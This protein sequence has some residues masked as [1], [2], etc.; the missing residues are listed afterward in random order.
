MLELEKLLP[1]KVPVR[2]LRVAELVK[3]VIAEAIAAQEIDSKIILDNF[4]T[5]S[6]VTVSPDL[7]NASVYITCFQSQNSKELIDELNKAAPKF[8]FLLAKQIKLKTLPHILFRYDDTLDYVEK[9]G[10]LL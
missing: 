10:S 6:K 1:K 3:K 4:I 2:Q 9:I 8:R 7:H 5:V